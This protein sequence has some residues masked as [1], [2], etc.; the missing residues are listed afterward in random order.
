VSDLLI[1]VCSV[2]LAVLLALGASELLLRST[3]WRQRHEPPP[4]QEPLRHRD[5]VLGWS[6][7]PGHVGYGRASGGAMVQYAF[8]RAGYRVRR[9]GDAVDTGRPTILFAGESIL[10][11][12][13]LPWSDGIPA[14][15]EAMTGVQS[16]NMTVDAFA[17]DQ[18]YLRLKA[19]LPRFRRPVAVVSVFVPSLFYRNLDDDRPHLDLGLTLRPP[20]RRWRIVELVLRGAPVRSQAE[21]ARGVA[22]TREIF[23]D[24]RRL[25]Q[26]RG[27]QA[28]IVVPQLTAETPAEH[29]LR[30]R[31]LDEAG[32]PY[33]YVAPD[34]AWRIPDNK[35]PDARAS[36][37]IAQAIAGRLALRNGAPPSLS[38]P[39]SPSR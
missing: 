38:R 24:T 22:L 12:H 39:A 17:N 20:V 3:A 27:A 15:V 7:V 37:V 11:G 21:I 18:S 9:P 6:I 4:N 32:L 23:A 2:A 29:A 25:A 28:L 13:G 31:V 10:G 5:P 8:D 26:A 1:D 36:R 34:P 33:V 16:A 14:Q 30:R 35:H 19:E